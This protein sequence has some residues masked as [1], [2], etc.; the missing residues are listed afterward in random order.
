MS[1]PEF[2][3]K[4]SAIAGKVPLP[5]QLADGQIAV[6]TKDGSIYTTKD[7]STYRINDANT[8]IFTSASS[9]PTISVGS[10]VSLTAASGL[11]LASTYNS[12]TTPSESARER[13]KIFGL[14]VKKH[15]D[16]VFEIATGGVVKVPGLMIS[17]DDIGKTFYLL[18]DGVS[19]RKFADQYVKL[20]SVFAAMSTDTVKIDFS[21]NGI[22]SEGA[23]HNLDGT[24]TPGPGPADP[25]DYNYLDATYA[26]ASSLGISTI[27][28]PGD[29]FLPLT[30]G[31]RALSLFAP[32]TE[33]PMTVANL[34]DNG[35]LYVLA[36][37][38]DGETIAYRTT[39][40]RGWRQNRLTA[41][42]QNTDKE[43][44]P[45]F[46]AAT[47]YIRNIYTPSENAAICEVYKITTPGG[48]TTHTFDRHVLMLFPG[49]FKESGVTG[50]DLGTG[51]VTYA[52][53]AFRNYFQATSTA[54]AL[55]DSVAM[56]MLRSCIPT[57]IQQPGGAIRILVPIPVALG[58]AA[59]YGG[60]APCVDLLS[61]DLLT[62][63]ITASAAAAAKT[64]DLLVGGTVTYDPTD[65]DSK[66]SGRFAVKSSLTAN[67][68]YTEPDIGLASSSFGPAGLYM[69]LPHMYRIQAFNSSASTI[70][71][72]YLMPLPVDSTIGANVSGA[73]TT[74]RFLLSVTPNDA[75]KVA[76]EIL[77]ANSASSIMSAAGSMQLHPLGK[78]VF[79]IAYGSTDYVRMTSAGGIANQFASSYGQSDTLQYLLADSSIMTVV[80]SSD[81]TL[82]ESFWFANYSTIKLSP[83]LREEPI[84][85][86]WSTQ[87]AM[88]PFIS[89]TPM[90]LV[91]SY[92]AAKTFKVKTTPLTP[93]VEKQIGVFVNGGMLFYP[94]DTSEQDSGAM[95]EKCAFVPTDLVAQS[96][97]TGGFNSITGA[98]SQA[99]PVTAERFPIVIPS[100][101]ISE[102]KLRT[103]PST[104]LW[105]VSEGPG[106]AEIYMN[107]HSCA[108]Y[109]DDDALVLA[110]QPTVGFK[111]IGISAPVAGKVELTTGHT[112]TV[113]AA[114]WANLRAEII[115]LNSL[116]AKVSGFTAFQMSVVLDVKSDAS[117]GPYQATVGY[118]YR[119]LTSG[120]VGYD[121]GAGY[122]SALLDVVG[123]VD[124]LDQTLTDFSRTA[125]TANLTPLASYIYIANENI[126]Q[127]YLRTQTMEMKNPTSSNR[128]LLS[129]SSR[130]AAALS[131][132]TPA[133]TRPLGQHA[134]GGTVMVNVAPPIGST[135]HNDFVFN[136]LKNS[137]SYRKLG[138]LNKNAGEDIFFPYEF[139]LS[140]GGAGST[141]PT[142]SGG[143]GFDLTKTARLSTIR[144]K[145][146]FNLYVTAPIPTLLNGVVHLAYPEA[147]NGSVTLP[148]E[149]LTGL[150]TVD[151]QNSTIY[152]Y[153]ELKNFATSLAAAK[154]MLPETMSRT[155]IG[156]VLTDSD[157]IT[158]T[159]I[160]PVFRIMTYRLSTTATGAAVPVSI[161]HPASG[162][163]TTW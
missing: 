88:L 79:D 51:L 131:Q 40:I 151:V 27:G 25:V 141:T 159:D 94:V 148:L 35:D 41:L 95:T 137:N 14:V 22:L 69:A 48:V 125:G 76:T 124:P 115:S 113:D 129:I 138:L 150:D 26:K 135:T 127:R 34:E 126:P 123:G 5:A 20:F 139:T 74:A 3:Q 64:S 57:A 145:G 45:Q 1:T 47:E 8:T 142:M 146:L 54:T 119:Y 105:E 15:S 136:C 65:T 17:P 56:K 154:T 30:D 70:S 4:R 121:I 100:E 114:F 149:T 66:F 16:T 162:V 68:E 23:I 111:T 93:L 107:T 10:V 32:K 55:S 61:V 98:I 87:Y 161:G 90:S 53:D 39:V 50:V 153:V 44:R 101:S 122:Y 63:V 13:S 112:V 78:Y 19:T 80:T 12:R 160:N 9:K 155:Y 60:D 24:W 120:E 140:W 89:G 33:L 6:N 59:A 103:V 134:V 31:V 62:G 132:S 75:V 110:K 85:D 102:N 96:L 130:T 18:A 116:G 144:A 118:M 133:F 58:K 84:G 108:F 67:I 71:M 46:L 21:E 99:V 72:T 11:E 49:S 86:S 163:G 2:K 42:V 109:Y 77:P 91:D 147:V 158:S 83:P 157:G 143:T 152:L 29:E 117:V 104:Y 82:D 73:Q 28:T 128:A 52:K 38:T 81:G 43:F 106:S 92:R 156:K 36:P 97:T 7:G 37:T